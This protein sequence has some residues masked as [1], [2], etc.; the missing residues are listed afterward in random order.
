[1]LLHNNKN[2]EA[3]RVFFVEVYELYI[4]VCTGAFFATVHPL[5]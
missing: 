3:V 2:E 1:M 4:K 5:T